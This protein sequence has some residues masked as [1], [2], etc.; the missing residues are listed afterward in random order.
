VAS[1]ELNISNVK[2][3]IIEAKKKIVDYQSIVNIFSNSVA[4]IDASWN[5]KNTPYFINII[6]QDK[7]EFNEHLESLREY[8]NSISVFCS[9]LSQLI[10]NEFSISSLKKIKYDSE[11][12]D[13]NIRLLDNCY[14][15]LN[16]SYY[17]LDTLYLPITFKYY[18]YL[19]KYKQDILNYRNEIYKMREKLKKV[20]AEILSLLVSTKQKSN[21]FDIKLVSNDICSHSF[22]LVNTTFTSLK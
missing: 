22:K 19:K 15:K 20:K 10:Q 3:Y 17:L 7:F 11:K 12:M 6:K 13:Y 8:L 2:N 18:F 1:F 21:L 5:D 9:V 14:E 16:R 4:N